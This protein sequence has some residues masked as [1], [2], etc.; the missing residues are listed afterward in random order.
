MF[1]WCC[2]KKSART[3]KR[4]MKFLHLRRKEKNHHVCSRILKRSNK[5]D[6]NPPPTF[7]GNK[8]GHGYELNRI[9]W[10]LFNQ[11]SSGSLM[12]ES[13]KPLELLPNKSPP[14]YKTCYL[15]RLITLERNLVPLALTILW[16]YLYDYSIEVSSEAFSRSFIETFSRRFM[17]L[18][19]DVSC[20]FWYIETSLGQWEQ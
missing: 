10:L 18:R 2:W 20:K 6:W 9:F 15:Y 12:S 11:D 3:H 7:T 16:K 19:D 1:I 5:V 17:R 4:Q 14:T 8:L 13:G